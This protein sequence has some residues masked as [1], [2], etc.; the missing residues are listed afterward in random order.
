M[1]EEA[2]DLRVNER[3]FLVGVDGEYAHWD[4]ATPEGMILD[5]EFSLEQLEALVAF[6]RT[7]AK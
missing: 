6:M 4:P 1:A 7:R 2:V 5:G 3:G